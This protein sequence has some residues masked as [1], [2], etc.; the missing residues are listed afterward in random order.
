MPAGTRKGGV[1]PP[2]LHFRAAAL[3][4]PSDMDPG[5][6]FYRFQSHDHLFYWPRV[7]AVCLR[8]DG[9]VSVDQKRDVPDGLVA[10]VLLG[11]VLADWLLWRGQLALHAN[12]V[13]LD[14]GVV[15]ITGAT[16]AGKST[17]GAAL[18]AAGGKPHCDDL[19]AVDPAS[20]T[21]PFG[22]QRAKLNPDVVEAIGLNADGA[23]P[24]YEGIDKR[25]VLLAAPAEADA[26][27]P[28]LCGIYR[29][30]DADVEAPGFE[31]LRSMQ[32]A[33]AVMMDVFRVEIEQHALGAEVLLER[34]A[35][36]AERVPVFLLRR[37]RD[38]A[39]LDALAHALL[40]HQQAQH[41]VG[42]SNPLD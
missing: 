15:A 39:Q 22:T 28:K 21:V 3:P 23:P 14:G 18:A 31:R 35:K 7:G 24:I 10:H 25:N 9:Q 5:E 8:A 37:K 33:L 6:G 34:C 42:D 30:V 12:G 4:L 29:L 17:L 20:A 13:V 26:E 2:D 11:A 16:G 36:L 1:G 40:A 27:S 32:A 41:A 19:L 38:L